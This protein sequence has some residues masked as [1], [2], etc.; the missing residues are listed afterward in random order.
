MIFRRS[1][2]FRIYLA[3][4]AQRDGVTACWTVMCESNKINYFIIINSEIPSEL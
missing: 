2:T 3:L 1:V 4:S